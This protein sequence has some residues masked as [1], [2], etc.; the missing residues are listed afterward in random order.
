MPKYIVTQNGKNTAPC[1]F[2]IDKYGGVNWAY[3]QDNKLGID[4]NDPTGVIIESPQVGQTFVNFET[5]HSHTI[6]AIFEA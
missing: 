1:L 4:D 2:G 3:T 6:V 5:G